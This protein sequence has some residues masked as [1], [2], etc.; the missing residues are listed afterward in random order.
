MYLCLRSP[1]PAP[2]EEGSHIYLP[3]SMHTLESGRLGHVGCLGREG[4]SG[5]RP[6]RWAGPSPGFSGGGG[7]GGDV[8]L[9]RR[10]AANWRQNH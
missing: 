5:L 3:A 9:R 4:R 1:A 10:L 6:V 2:P 7:G 8:A